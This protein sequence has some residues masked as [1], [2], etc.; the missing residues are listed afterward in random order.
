MSESDKNA[1]IHSTYTF[2][3]QIMLTMKHSFIIPYKIIVQY[4]C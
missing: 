4:L 1:V 2:D 3:E